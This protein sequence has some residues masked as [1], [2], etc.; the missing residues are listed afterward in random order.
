MY[1]L[2]SV[3]V[4]SGGVLGGHYYAYI[5]PTIEGDAWFKFDDERVTKETTQKA[6]VEQFG[7]SDDDNYN[8]NHNN[9]NNN[10]TPPAHG[11]FRLAKFS[12]A[13]M[14]VYVRESD[15]DEILCNVD[16][17]DIL[18]HVRERLQREQE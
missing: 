6:T 13:Y 16:K 7:G 2:H 14:L 4:H 5:R 10:F 8:H 18:P 11:G 9:N 17:E 1:L 15:K 3:L 12:N